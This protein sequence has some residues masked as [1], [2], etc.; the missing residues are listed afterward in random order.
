MPWIEPLSV[1]LADGVTII[2]RATENEITLPVATALAAETTLADEPAL[3]SNP[4]EPFALFGESTL[5]LAGDPTE[6]YALFSE[7][8]LTIALR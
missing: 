2:A 6:R 4:T 1:V 7:R 3:A 8:T 5:A